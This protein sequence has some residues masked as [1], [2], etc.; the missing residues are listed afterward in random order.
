MRQRTTY[1]RPIPVTSADLQ[2]CCRNNRF[3][4]CANM[5]EKGSIIETRV[6]THETTV[7]ASTQEET[8]I[9]NQLSLK[10]LQQT[11]LTNTL[12]Q[13]LV[14]ITKEFDQQK[15][16]LVQARKEKHDADLEVTRLSTEVENITQELFEQANSQVKE[17]NEDAF[18]IKQL[19]DRLSNTIKEKD[20]TIEILQSELSTLKHIISNLDNSSNNNTPND[21]SR[22]NSKNVS[23]ANLP[24][25]L[26][27]AEKSTIPQSANFNSTLLSAFNGRPIYSPLFNQLRFDLP[28]FKVFSDVLLTKHHESP[29]SKIT[30]F[31]IKTSKFFIK[32]LEELEDM[33][34]LDKSPALQS[35]KLRWNRKAFLLE[36]M[37]KT[38][39]IEPLSAVTEVWK[40]QTLQQYIPSISDET[41]TPPVSAPETDAM[42]SLSNVSTNTPA[43]PYDPSL[44]KYS[45]NT[46]KNSSQQNNIVPLAVTTSCGLCGETR[47]DLN[48]S[49]LY[50]LRIES[51]L[52]S[53]S[54]P[55]S[56][57]EK[58]SKPDYPLCINC[59]NK[60]RS[61]V[62]LLKFVSSLNPL[63]LSPGVKLDDYIRSSWARYVELKA[64]MWYSVSFGIWNDKE[65]FGLV[66]GWQNDWLVANLNEKHEKNLNLL[67]SKA[68]KD[69]HSSSYQVSDSIPS[70]EQGFEEEQ[71][72][73][74]QQEPQP[75]SQSESQLESQPDY[76]SES[77]SESQSQVS[78]DTIPRDLNNEK[79][80][81]PKSISSG[82][83]WNGWSGVIAKAQTDTVVDVGVGVGVGVA[84]KRVSSQTLS[85]SQRNSI[86]SDTDRVNTTETKDTTDDD[87]NF[88]DASEGRTT[89]GAEEISEDVD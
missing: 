79:A 12:Q 67:N 25:V 64:R 69:E 53:V 56:S 8:D 47:M 18:N 66:Y 24:G 26:N 42:P 74:K 32:L 82:K 63:K 3:V 85:I 33:L 40:N 11:E 10:L 51:S 1:K 14:N 34:R 15:R 16:M 46:N 13:R 84:G 27:D 71:E 54:S 70:P 29:S 62:E 31:D 81:T 21:D 78:L 35:L 72:S 86:I 39:N 80:S 23:N 44:F 88:E 73:G 59:A 37:E 22:N 48:F 19:N 38:V 57:G 20:T 17:A 89:A 7:V 65:M 76:Q 55:S 5:A 2:F 58:S 6:E 28:S 68:L 4:F 45:S 77:Q 30:T 60:Y 49:R 83:G 50:H 43:A 36:L 75:E 61:V 52:S 41:S 87:G 9:I